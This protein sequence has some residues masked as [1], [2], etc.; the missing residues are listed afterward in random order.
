[1][2]DRFFQLH[3]HQTTVRRE[4]GAGATTFV[5]MSYIIFVQ[6]VVLGAAGMDPGAVM[7]ATCLSSAL[8]TLL[9]GL[10]ANYPIALAPGMGHNFFFTYTVVILLGYTWQQ[11]LGA[12]FVSGV[13]FIVLAFIG[14]RER[15]L[16]AVPAAL[17]NGIAAGI[18]LLI[19]LVGLQWGGIVVD[20][21]GTLVQLG[22]LGSLP[23]LLTVLGLAVTSILLAWRVRA[24]ILLGIVTTL[25]VGLALGVTEFH[26]V[27]GR[28][29][30]LRATFLQLDVLGALQTGMLSVIFVFFF[31][32]LFD[33]VGT[34]IGVTQEAGLVREDG[35][36]PRAR[37][38]LLADAIGT[39]SGTLLGTS[40]ITS[41]VESAAGVTAGGRT[42]LAS[43]VTALLF[44]S[45]L[46]CAPLVAMIGR[47]VPMGEGRV[48]YPMVAP[49]LILVG[50]YMMKSVVRI[51]WSDPS[52][53]IPAFL[54]I[55][56]MP[57]T[58]SITEG[59]A[60]GFIAYVVLKGARGRL[61]EVPLL[62]Q[63]FAG[64]FV[65]RY[66]LLS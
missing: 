32:D 66:L 56:V 46:F 13:L 7:T 59:I 47:G 54:T 42:G 16:N 38:A 45:A 1:M 21:P 20:S 30:A 12:I 31:L 55:L 24:A 63:V 44:V 23:V 52:E 65:L 29:P 40:T 3:A 19:A 34:L 9:M 48:L 41:Y 14:F 10:L 22:S 2:L 60:F 33:T 27:V 50:S 49:A 15:L 26:G 25:V 11:A 17:R 51:E 57:L 35:T 5:T 43:V 53:A 39:V 6:P 37:G 61:R 4:I 18:G 62:I 8:A 36:L 28:P 64:L 58:F